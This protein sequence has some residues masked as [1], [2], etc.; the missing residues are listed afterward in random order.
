[1]DGIELRLSA[2]FRVYAHS[3]VVHLKIALRKI[4]FGAAA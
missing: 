3:K 2:I 4:T 1:V